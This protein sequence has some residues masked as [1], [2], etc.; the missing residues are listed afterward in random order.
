MLASARISG[1]RAYAPDTRADP[2]TGR[3]ILGPGDWE[4]I[5]TP[6]ETARIREILAD[7]ARRP[8]APAR[9]SLLGGIARC[10]KCGAGLTVTSHTARPGA[11]ATRRY[12]CRR[13]PSRPERGGLSINANQLDAYVAERVLHRLAAPKTAPR[14]GPVSG[15]LAEIARINARI[16]QIERDYREQCFTPREH[17]AAIQAAERALTDAGRELSAAIGQVTPLRAAPVGDEGALAVWWA[18]LDVLAQRAVITALVKKLTIM[19]G[20]PGRVFDVSRV[21]LSYVS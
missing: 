8:A 19:P 11:V 20:S 12:G 2:A 1:Q 5:I 17:S 3:E 9:L 4:A 7:P 6:A 18:A 10:G 15:L 13:D 16:T 14:P 21:R